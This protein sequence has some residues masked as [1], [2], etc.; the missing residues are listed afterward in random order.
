MRFWKMSGGR[1]AWY[2]IAALVLLLAG[3]DSAAGAG[4]PQLSGIP[5]QTSR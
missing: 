1:A 3:Y 5:R 2:L 4:K